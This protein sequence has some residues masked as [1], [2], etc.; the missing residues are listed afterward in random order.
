[1]RTEGILA[2]SDEHKRTD[3]R[4]TFPED[5]TPISASEG[6]RTATKVL[7]KREG[8]VIRGKELL[9]KREN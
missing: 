1:M 8:F 6:L 9:K 3:T 4:M 5:T 2:E 7:N